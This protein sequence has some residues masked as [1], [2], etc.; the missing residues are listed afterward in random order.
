M[1][2]PFL[3]ELFAAMK[4]KA[5]DAVYVFG[6]SLNPKTKKNEPRLTHGLAE[7]ARKR[8]KKTSEHGYGGPE[9]TW[10]QLRI[11]CGTFLANSSIFGAASAYREARQLGHSVAIAER[12]YLG[13]VSVDPKARTLEAAMEITAL[14]RDPLGLSLANR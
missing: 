8:L 14:L 5:D 11:T 2:S 6:E 7:A 10:Q 13:V 1:V 3:A 9:F 12:D 4:L